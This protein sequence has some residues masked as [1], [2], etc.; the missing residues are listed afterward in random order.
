MRVLIFTNMQPLKYNFLAL[1][2]DNTRRH[3]LLQ[4]S[5]RFPWWME[6]SLPGV[7]GQL[8]VLFIVLSYVCFRISLLFV[9]VA[10]MSLFAVQ[11]PRLHAMHLL[12]QF[13]LLM[14]GVP[15]I[16]LLPYTAK[17]KTRKNSNWKC[18]RPSGPLTSSILPSWIGCLCFGLVQIGIV[19]VATH[20]PDW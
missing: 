6:R 12:F 1:T 11:F 19:W 5:F 15:S 8:S 4:P 14:I 18:L 20:E 17:S 3:L 10:F 13:L 2:R 7:R 9:N 16:L